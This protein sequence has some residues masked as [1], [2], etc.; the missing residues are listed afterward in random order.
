MCNDT[1][2]AIVNFN[3][4]LLTNCCVKSVLK[5]HGGEFEITIFDNSTRDKFVPDACVEKNVR[6]VDNTAGAYID[7]EDVVRQNSIFQR[8]PNGHG[9]L[10]HAYTVD[11]LLQHS[12]KNILLMDSDT[13]L[14][15]KIDFIDDSYVT[16]ASIL[17]EKQYKNRFLP[18]IQFFNVN[19]INSLGLR[20]FDRNRILFGAHPT[21]SFQYDTG[22]SFLEDCRQ[23]NLNYAEIDYTQYVNHLGSGSWKTNDVM[24]FLKENSE[25]YE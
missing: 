5:Q 20:Y 13:V 10:K 18:F 8:T 16:V 4:T 24:K 21:N 15:R 7:F 12:D 19:R 9:S 23:M 11:Y 3:T 1:V 22:T 25:F 14:K 17:R 2:I 6:I